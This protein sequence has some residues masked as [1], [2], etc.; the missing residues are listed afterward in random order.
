M[1]NLNQRHAGLVESGLTLPAAKAI[2]SGDLAAVARLLRTVA[3]VLDDLKQACG[4]SPA[5]PE[6]VL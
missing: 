3:L 1:N 6:E 5:V 2:S 4:D